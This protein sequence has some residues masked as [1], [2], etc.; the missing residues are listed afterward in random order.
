ME[1][2]TSTTDQRIQRWLQI[3]H[4][5]DIE[6]LQKKPVKSILELDYT[7]LNDHFEN[8]YKE[9]ILDHPNFF[10]FLTVCENNLNKKRSSNEHISLKIVDIPYSCMLKDLNTDY[11]GKFISTNAMVKNITPIQARIIKAAYEC[12]GCM[13]LHF[14]E[15]KEGESLVMPSLC[16]EC[17]SRSFTLLPDESEFI[18]TRFVKLE[19]P[20]ELRQTGMTREFKAYMDKYLAN[21]N[22][23]IKPGDVCEVSG[24]FDVVK[25]DKTKEWDFLLKLHNI[26]PQNSAFE[27]INLSKEDIKEIQ[28]LSEREDIF[29]LLVNSIAP[30]VYGYD[31][32]KEGIV[33]Q[34]FEGKDR[35]VIYLRLGIR[36]VGLFMFC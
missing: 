32:I 18:D 15:I 16:I 9:S 2:K 35:K 10:N 21:P 12:R 26:K 24:L 6:T 29:K 13:K 19:E 4:K 3:Y 25:N 30:K 34:L 11:I 5:E 8:H 1:D 36:I 20:L 22:Y 17:G 23:T 7:E 33:L 14:I 28:G 27:E 31:F